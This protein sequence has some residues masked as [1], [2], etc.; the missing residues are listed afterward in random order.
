[1]PKRKKR[2]KIIKVKPEDKLVSAKVD[3]LRPNLYRKY[4]SYKEIPRIGFD[5]KYISI[6]PAEQFFISDTTFRDGQQ[7]RPPYT[8]E[9]IVNIYKLISR[10]SGPKGTIRYSE[11][12]LYTEKDQKA[13]VECQK[14]KR[15]YPKITGWIRAKKED[16]K[17][18][19]KMGL[20]ET[21]ILTSA[22]DYH[23]FLKL[24]LD[25][26]KAIKKYLDIVIKAI[27][28]GIVPRCHFEDATRADIYGFCV[29]FAQELMKLREQSGLD[30][31]IRI[32]D[33]MGVGVPFPE[34]SLPRSVPKL[35]RAFTKDANVPS[36]LLEWHGHNDF[37]KVLVNATTAW[38]YGC[39][40]INCALLGFGERTGNTPLEAMVI[41]YISLTGDSEGMD[42]TAITDIAKYIEK[43]TD[44]VIPG[45]FPLAGERFNATAAGIHYDGILKNEEVYNIFDTKKILNRPPSIIINDK[46]GAAGITYWVNSYLQRYGKGK[47]DKR[48]SGVTKI[49]TW[50]DE[51]YKRG[52]IT[53]ISDEEMELEVKKFF[54]E[55]FVSEFERLTKKAKE[56][57]HELIDEIAEDPDIKSLDPKR[58]ANV[59]RREL[60]LNPFIKFAYVVDVNGTQLTPNVFQRGDASKYKKSFGIGTDFSDREWFNKALRA[61]DIYYS[62]FFISRFTN[63]LCITVSSPIKNSK[64]EIIAIVGIDLAYEYLAKISPNPV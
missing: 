10:L 13:V 32:C 17:L 7:A 19:K 58:M 15:K 16:F 43:E 47:I 64:G 27:E 14:L 49:K 56:L 53:N 62:D 11:F 57:A 18:V 23:I 55:F 34:A 1:M 59:L 8:V 5:D 63:L 50:I 37:H 6:S 31:K 52:R 45:N 41:E 12:F 22:S 60:K 30:V 25:R 42:T 40:T 26:K 2:G 20:K 44:T 29:P 4:F 21:G 48:H 33:T 3:R 51:E 24:K 28:E 54:P 9:Q 46:S 36:H 38:L 39:G 61:G 35:I